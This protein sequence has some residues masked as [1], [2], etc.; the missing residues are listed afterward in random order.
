MVLVLKMLLIN[1]VAYACDKVGGTVDCV[2]LVIGMIIGGRV[3]VVVVVVLVIAELEE[4]VVEND[5][6]T[7][8]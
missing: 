6:K 2:D 8:N 5:S 3:V 4:L 7:Q 1:V